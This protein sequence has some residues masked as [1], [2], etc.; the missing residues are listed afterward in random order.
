VAKLGEAA[1]SA[2]VGAAARCHA[3]LATC[4]ALEAQKRVRWW[5]MTTRMQAVEM[6][7]GG[8]C[9]PRDYPDTEVFAKW[10][11]DTFAFERQRSV[12]VLSLAVVL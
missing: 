11:A 3:A 4:F 12:L 2:C 1:G 8:L 9:F 5:R 10:A 7:R 6:E